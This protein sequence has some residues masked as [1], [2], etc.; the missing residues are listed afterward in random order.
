MRDGRHGISSGCSTE[1]Q[2]WNEGWGM[3]G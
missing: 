1:L 3:A 2:H